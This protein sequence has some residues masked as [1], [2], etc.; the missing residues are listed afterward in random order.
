MK[1][2]VPHF[3]HNVTFLENLHA[4]FVDGSVL[5]VRNHIATVPFYANKCVCNN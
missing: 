2:S 3:S 5:D 4:I 1:N